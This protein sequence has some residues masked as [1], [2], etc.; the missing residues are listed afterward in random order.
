MKQKIW[1]LTWDDG[2]AT[3]AFE[4]LEDAKNYALNKVRETIRE[5]EEDEYQAVVKELN[6]NYDEYKGFWIDGWFWC[7]AIEFY[8]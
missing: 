7:N 3:A 1:L 2:Y 8:R 5:D 4:K 6:D